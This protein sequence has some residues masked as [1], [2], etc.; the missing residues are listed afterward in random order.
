M[1]LPCAAIRACC[2]KLVYMML[3]VAWLTRHSM[4]VCQHA[5]Q[6]SDAPRDASADDF[7]VWLGQYVDETAGPNKWVTHAT[8]VLMNLWQ[9]L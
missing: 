2:H 5:L 4:D 6:D 7:R 9:V 1:Q 8:V 3:T